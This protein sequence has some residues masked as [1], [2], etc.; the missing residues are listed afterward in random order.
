MHPTT[1][2]FPTYPATAK[3]TAITE[4]EAATEADRDAN[5]TDSKTENRIRIDGNEEGKEKPD[6]RR[7]TGQKFAIAEEEG[8]GSEA[9]KNIILA[10][11]PAC[12]TS[13]QSVPIE[14]SL[15]SYSNSKRASDGKPVKP[16]KFSFP[17]SADEGEEV[18]ET[19]ETREVPEEKVQEEK[20]RGVDDISSKEGNDGIDTGKQ[21][22]ESFVKILNEWTFTE[23][24][25]AIRGKNSRKYFFSR[26]R[27]CFFSFIN[28]FRVLRAVATTYFMANRLRQWN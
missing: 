19:L 10:S 5:K 20:E 17:S 8:R 28:V 1:L 4:T 15:A 2:I 26:R 23:Q 3:A 14:K 24:Q 11:L 18:N 7:K 12:P 6:K 9:A 16:E 13:G 22:V 21:Q 25:E 27:Q